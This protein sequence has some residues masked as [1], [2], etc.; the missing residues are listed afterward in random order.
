MSKSTWSKFQSETLLWKRNKLDYLWKWTEAEPEEMIRKVFNLYL[1]PRNLEAKIVL[2]GF[3]AAETNV[4]S[5]PTC[6]PGKQSKASLLLAS[7]FVDKFL[8][9]DTHFDRHLIRS[10]CGRMLVWHTFRCGGAIHCSLGFGRKY[11][12]TTNLP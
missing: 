2:L 5:C 12:S 10:I 11:P 3:S 9:Y 8:E 6:Q 7:M 4:F 1:F